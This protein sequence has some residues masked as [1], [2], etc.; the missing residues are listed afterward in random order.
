M[1]SIDRPEKNFYVLTM[2]LTHTHRYLIYS[3]CSFLLKLIKED[4]IQAIL[5]TAQ[6]LVGIKIHLFSQ[7]SVPSPAPGAVVLRSLQG[8]TSWR[9]TSGGLVGGW[10]SGVGEVGEVRVGGGV[11]PSEKEFRLCSCPELS[12]LTN[13]QLIATDIGVDKAFSE[14]FL[15]LNKC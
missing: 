1:K 11:S 3:I 9:G 8:A 10:G 7:A 14:C 2:T 13:V 5:E 15:S 12:S 6:Q 4:L